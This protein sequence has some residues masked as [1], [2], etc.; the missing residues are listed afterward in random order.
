[1]HYGLIHRLGSQKWSKASVHSSAWRPSDS[2][3]CFVH[4]CM[5]V[6][7]VRGKCDYFQ[8]H[9]CDQSLESCALI[10]L[11]VF[12]CWSFKR[13][14]KMKKL[15]KTQNNHYFF[16]P[17]YIGNLEIPTW[18]SANNGQEEERFP[19]WP[20]TGWKGSLF[21]SNVSRS[22][23]SLKLCL[24]DRGWKKENQV[25]GGYQLTWQVKRMIH[26]SIETHRGHKKIER[27]SKKNENE[28]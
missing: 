13:S 22:A 8:S 14:C 11:L 27:P 28:E 24:W 20:H 4:P 18:K 9:I 2:I 19:W 15:P 21:C 6:S 12:T 16:P 5:W 23:P 10:S 25:L 17:K 26:S 7:V 1:M 3:L